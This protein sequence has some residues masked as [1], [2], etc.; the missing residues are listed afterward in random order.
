MQGAIDRQQNQKKKKSTIWICINL[1]TI[2]STWRYGK[3]CLFLQYD[4]LPCIEWRGLQRWRWRY[5][6]TIK[7]RYSIY[8]RRRKNQNIGKR[9]T[10]VVSFIKRVFVEWCSVLVKLRFLFIIATNDVKWRGK[11]MCRDFH[12]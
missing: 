4:K 1:D 12:M 11:A 2:Y 10:C 7:E 9:K 3:Q 5:Y 8:R 6:I